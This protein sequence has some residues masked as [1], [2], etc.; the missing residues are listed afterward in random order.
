[1]PQFLSRSEGHKEGRGIKK[2]NCFYGL[3]YSIPRIFLLG[4]PSARREIAAGQN[5]KYKT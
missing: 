5:S 2:I 1:M 4:P 3:K